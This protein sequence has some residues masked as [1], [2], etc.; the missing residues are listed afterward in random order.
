[1]RPAPAASQQAYADPH[2][3]AFRHRRAHRHRRARWRPGSPT[4]SSVNRWWWARPG[5]TGV[6]EHQAGRRAPRRTGTPSCSAPAARWASAPA[7]TPKLPTSD[8]VTDCACRWAWSPPSTTCWWV[9]PRCWRPTRGSSSIRQGQSG[10][11]RLRLLGHR[12]HLS[13]GS[14]L[15]GG[16]QTGTQLTTCPGMRTGRAGPAGRAHPDDDACLLLHSTSRRARSRRHRQP[17]AQCRRIRPAGPRDR[18]QFRSWLSS[19]R[20]AEGH[21]RQ[22]QRRPHRVLAN[23]EV[24]GSA[25]TSSVR[26]TPVSPTNCRHAAWRS[27]AGTKLVRDANI[28]WSESMTA[29]LYAMT[30]DRLGNGR[31]KDLIEGGNGRR[32]C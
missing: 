10:Q 15:F 18:R 12:Q 8:V 4:F 6:A 2:R 28:R 31:M 20:H 7:I 11:G 25:S 21:R 9:H 30:C 23:P 14:A 13:P 24:R 3:R 1:M 26:A 17:Q 27:G 5:A 19:C 16:V 29:T 32:T 22:A